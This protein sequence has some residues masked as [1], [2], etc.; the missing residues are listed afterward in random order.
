MDSPG[1][2]LETNLAPGSALLE[3]NV[4]GRQAKRSSNRLLVAAL[5][6]VMG[7]VLIALSVPLLPLQDPLSLIHI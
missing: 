7:L 3:S 1:T 4:A 5:L 2:Y 6:M